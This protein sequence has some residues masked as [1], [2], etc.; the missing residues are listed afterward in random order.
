M[1]MASIVLL[2]ISD[3]RAS[4]IGNS[5]TPSEVSDTEVASNE[6]QGENS[7]NS[8]SATITITWRTAPLPDK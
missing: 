2:G 6:A 1:L 5:A 4:V 3:G 8:S 7:S